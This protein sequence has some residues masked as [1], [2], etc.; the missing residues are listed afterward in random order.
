MDFFHYRRGE[1]CCESVPLA[2]IAAAVGTPAYVYSV[3][4]L[5]SGYR[6]LASAFRGVSCVLCYSV[7]ANSNLAI[8][9]ELRRLGAGFDIVSGGELYRVLRA[10]CTPKQVVFSGVGKTREEID[11]A[12]RRGILL[13]NVES[14]AELEML[15]DRAQRLQRRARVLVRVNPDVDP[16][17]HP[18]ISTGRQVHKFGVYWEEA[19]PLCL[20]AAALPGVEFLGIGCH[21]GSQIMRLKP[22]R[23]AVARLQA[24]GLRLQRSGLRVRYLD[25]GGGWVF[26]TRKRSRSRLRATRSKL[27][28]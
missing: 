10:G 25:F 2:R 22:F 9:R 26:A 28:K 1:L 18:H 21:I 16:H 17:T 14:S 23:E 19:R 3:A 12:L 5:R 13:F 27:R 7:K 8:L 4:A 15:A 11:F 20:R 6:R 24:L